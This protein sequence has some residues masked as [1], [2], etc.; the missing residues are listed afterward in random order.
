MGNLKR[1]I[2][3][4]EMEQGQTK[5][6]VLDVW[7]GEEPDQALREHLEACPEHEGIGLVVFVSQFCPRPPGAER[8][9]QVYSYQGKR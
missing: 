4:L 2:E 6:L 9:A 3:K 7:K 1:R 5:M 8:E